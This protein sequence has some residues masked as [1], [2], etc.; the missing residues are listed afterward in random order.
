[1]TERPFTAVSRSS[2]TLRQQSF[3][4]RSGVGSAIRWTRRRW[5]GAPELALISLSGHIFQYRSGG[6]VVEGDYGCR[7]PAQLLLGSTA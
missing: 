7:R 6:D 1:M 3:E 5:S 2:V 4:G